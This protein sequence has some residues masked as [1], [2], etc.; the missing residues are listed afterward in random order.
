MEKPDFSHE[1]D[2][3]SLILVK[4][5]GWDFSMYVTPR[6]RQHYG[7][8]V[9]EQT[10][11]KCVVQHLARTRLFIDV[12]A[13]YGFYTLLAAKEGKDLEVIAFE[14]TPE[15][16]RVLQKNVTLNGV[17]NVK[18]NQVALSDRD[19]L[20]QFNI[21]L[22]S[23]SC[24]FYP[25]PEAMPLR[26]LEVRANR[27]DTFLARRSPCSTLI[28]IDTEGH[29][30]AVLRGLTD[31]IRRFADL[32]FL[33]EFNPLMQ[34]AACYAQDALLSYL[35]DCGYAAFFLNETSGAITLVKNQD[36]LSNLVNE[37]GYGNLFCERPPKVRKPLLYSID[38]PRKWN[39]IDRDLSIH[40]WCFSREDIAIEAVRAR[41]GK[42]I[43]GGR[44][45][46][47]RDDV[48]RVY[49]NEPKALLSG[50]EVSAKIPILP[51]WLKLEARDQ[52]CRWHPLEGRLVS[53]WRR[54]LQA[55]AF[56]ASAAAQQEQVSNML[57]RVF[58]SL[59]FES[60]VLAVSHSDYRI[61]VAGTQKL[62]QQEEAL[63]AEREISYVEI[64]PATEQP[65][66]GGGYRDFLMGLYVDSQKIGTFTLAQIQEFMAAF[67]SRDIRIEAVH[68]HHLM[69]FDLQLID[70]LLANIVAPKTVF[71][72]DFYTVC[73]Q[74]NLMKN[75]TEFCAAPPV[76]S[77]T[78]RNC[79]YGQE[80][81][82]HFSA[83]SAF[84][85]KWNVDFI[86]PST[87]ARDVW[88]K[89]FPTLVKRIKVIPHLVS[90][91]AGGV[92]PSPGA[93]T[94]DA[95]KL[96]E[97]QKV[98]SPVLSP[99]VDGRSLKCT[100]RRIRI[101]YVGYQH[102]IKGWEDWKRLAGALPSEDFECFILGNCGEFFPHVQYVPVSFIEQGPDAMRQAL[103]KNNIDLAFLWSLVPETYSF[104]L[105]EAMAAGCFILTNPYSGNIAAQVTESGRGWI[106][107][108][109]QDLISSLLKTDELRA[110]LD[111]FHAQY[112][113][114]DLSP[115]P[116]LPDEIASRRKHTQSLSWARAN[117]ATPVIPT[118]A[119]LESPESQNGT[120]SEM[121][122]FTSITSNYLPKAAVL[123]NSLRKYRPGAEFYVLLCDRTPVGLSRFEK[124]FNKIFPLEQ[125]G[126][127]VAN[128]E[129]WIFKHSMVE[130]CTAVKGPFLRKVFDE[131]RPR[132][133]VYFDPDIVVL[134]DLVEL[135]TLLDNHSVIVTPHLVDPENVS[136]AILDNEVCSLQHG[137]FNLGFLAVRNSAEGRRFVKW[138]SD[139]LM[140]FCYDDI[141]HGLFTDQ[142]W[143]DLAPAFFDD[144]HILRDKTY[145]VAT[146][147]LSQRRVEK[148]ADE[149]L[150]IEGR[151]VKFF[152]FSGF[153]SGAQLEMLKKYGQHSPALLE[154]RERYIQELERA[155]QLQF[156]SLPWG[157]GCFSNGQPILTDQ[158]RLYRNRT[159]LIAAFP[160][161][162]QVENGRRSYYKWCTKH[163]RNGKIP[164][165]RLPLLKRWERSIKKRLPFRKHDQ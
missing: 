11:A 20:T 18:V 122:F 79:R 58:Q 159:D 100:G 131:L 76:G 45:G 111:Q 56:P 150:C 91:E 162:A 41:R 104:T 130:L 5:Q 133:V 28:K 51:G 35:H 42:H 38:V 57:P 128:A 136:G 68:L 102:V 22:A 157:Y 40:G 137:V 17:N 158:R 156:G 141:P 36:D 135:E 71:I 72:H 19:A 89:A 29:E 123:A 163:F 87:L 139:R 30:L 50:F 2:L 144:F 149:R 3:D 46:L 69:G 108:D 98:D 90:R 97:K 155:G 1:Y 112:P 95:G 81:P 132:K 49:P 47:S 75:D 152:H 66:L 55:R 101:A 94:L 127:P 78:C 34:R 8:F 96:P 9:F 116:Q 65:L 39:L 59:R 145:N 142:R 99:T 85:E 105:F 143:M 32:R 54:L 26:S 134:D 21:S 121:V 43:W 153:D 109:L 23:D 120:P 31:T 106:A 10:S 15:T 67:G 77:E 63:L 64:H 118:H 147:N 53:R 93:A 114:F 113:R 148:R 44:Y 74:W 84:F 117:Q 61:A 110:S 37:R 24:G 33:I 6:Y 138:W 107:K 124:I 115:N 146:W 48:A 82:A 103:Q 164:G 12:G 140:Q 80:R 7:D 83:Y 16:C 4:P 25:N 154:L 86:T 165:D 92:C 129:Q 119:A 52:Y 70:E 14:P 160:R 62:L 13:H 125:L 73:K 88:L 161:P 151:P 60:C 27:L 126:L